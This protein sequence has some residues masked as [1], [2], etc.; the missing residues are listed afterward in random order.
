MYAAIR[1]AA[2][3]QPLLVHKWIAAAPVI[4]AFAAMWFIRFQ[5]G[6]P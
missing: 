4:P 1:I 6:K 5:A 3:T 2:L